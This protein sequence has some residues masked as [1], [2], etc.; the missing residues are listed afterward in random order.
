[1]SAKRLYGI[2]MRWLALTLC[3]SPASRERGGQ[4]HAPGRSNAVEVGFA[5]IFCPPLNPAA[6]G[7]RL[8][9][10]WW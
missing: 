7:S 5:H 10:V 9:G 3:L 8:V 4:N 6:G 2:G 1:M